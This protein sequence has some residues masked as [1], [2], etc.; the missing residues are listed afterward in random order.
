[1]RPAESRNE[2]SPFQ[3]IELH[4]IPAS[5][6]RIAAYRI[7]ED[8]SGGNG[9]HSG[10]PPAAPITDEIFRAA[11]LLADQQKKRSDAYQQSKQNTDDERN[12]PI[13]TLDRFRPSGFLRCSEP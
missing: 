3:L 5:Q 13:P 8:Q 1:V 7:S 9:D 12:N 11:S 4:S 6:G 2:R 10:R